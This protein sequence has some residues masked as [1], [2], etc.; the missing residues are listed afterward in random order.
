MKIHTE[1]IKIKTKTL[2]SYNF[3]PSFLKIDV[4]GANLDV[5]SGWKTITA[6]RLIQVENDADARTILS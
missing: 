5:M 6:Y 4:E 1:I 3:K 2:D